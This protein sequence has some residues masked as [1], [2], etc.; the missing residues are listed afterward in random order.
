M[1]ST[2]RVRYTFEGY[3]LD[4]VRGCLWNGTRE[5]E[6]RP[7]S[8]ELLR[9]LVKNPDRLLVKEEMANACWPNV[10]V[11][12]ASLA[13]CISDL[14]SALN[15]DQRRLIKTIPCRGYL[16]AAP[17]S[18][19][20]AED[21][22]ALSALEPPRFSIVVLPFANLSGEP[23]QDYFA[24]GIVEEI[25]TALSRI[26][27]FF[28]IART[29]AFAY[30]GRAVDVRQVGQE[31]GVRYVL[32]GSVRQAGD[33]VRTTGQLI[34]AATGAYLW[35][36]RYDHVLADVFAVQDQITE[37]VVAAIQAQLYAAEDFR[38]RR[39]PPANLDAWE[40]VI[41]AL[42]YMG[43]GTRAADAEAEMLCRR[44]IAIAPSYGQAHSLLAWVLIRRAALAGDSI[45]SLLPE[46]RAEA[47]TALSLDQGD[48]WAHLTYGA[49]LWRN[50]RHQEAERA[51]YRAL[52]LNPNFALAHALIAGALA[53]E[54]A[55]ERA[56]AIAEY[57]HR[58][59][60]ND[61]LVDFYASR[62]IK[63]AH[64]GTENYAESLVWARRLTERYPEYI[65]GFTWL[66]ATAGLHG[67]META[68]EALAELRRLRPHFSLAWMRENL[69]FSDN[70]LERLLAGLRTAGL[71][72]R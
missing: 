51:F 49:V 32:E 31:L 24:D 33:R 17:V 37:R 45:K 62:A 59:S 48:A 9:Y 64:L 7:K 12:D 14:R 50:R 70:V 5:I 15:D 68:A 19:S 11:S 21:T 35:A 29:S 23:A 71:P 56:L 8:F 47:R 43:Q 58:L 3:T 2:G 44:A 38:S 20:A 39:K 28:V 69:P 46:A 52:A 55:H 72:E 1:S 30:K 13:Q 6:L 27:S 26:R 67:D 22:S 16:F 54:G 53:A 40:C 61:R 10:I 60:P 25:T 41:R 65:P 42:S 4:L 36:E 63:Y 18:I 66:A 57:A 34:E